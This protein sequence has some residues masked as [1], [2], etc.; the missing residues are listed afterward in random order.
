M[1]SQHLDSR[2]I[3]HTRLA[4]HFLD[5]QTAS[6]LREVTP[7]INHRKGKHKSREQQRLVIILQK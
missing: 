7:E 5:E 3:P 4:C 1:I 2:Q 6:K